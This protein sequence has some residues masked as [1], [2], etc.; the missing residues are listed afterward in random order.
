MC[1]AAPMACMRVCVVRRVRDDDVVKR[2]K[3]EFINFVCGEC[4]RK[5]ARAVTA[6]GK[7]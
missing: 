3:N 5:L 4:A 1:C 2:C 6:L 7:I